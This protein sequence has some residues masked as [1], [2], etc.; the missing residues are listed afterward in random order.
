MSLI[1]AKKGTVKSSVNVHTRILGYFVVY[2]LGTNLH[3]R[4]QTYLNGSLNCLKLRFSFLFC[5][6]N[7]LS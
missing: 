5:L 4:I 3:W 1:T 2:G 6:A 7:V